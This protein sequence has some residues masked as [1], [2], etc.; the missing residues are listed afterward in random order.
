MAADEGTAAHELAAM[1]LQSDTSPNAEAYLGRRM[2]VGK[3]TFTVDRE[4]ADAV[5]L[6]V[7]TVLSIAEGHELLVEQRVDYSATLNVPN[8]FGTSDAIIITPDEII[9][10]D[11]KYGANPRNR[12]GARDNRQMKLYALGA[13]EEHGLVQNFSRVRMMIVQPRLDNP[14]SEDTITMDELQMFAAE[15][16][17]AAAHAMDLLAKGAEK[18]GKYDLNPTVKGCK[19][20]K[21]ASRCPARAQLVF[22]NVKEVE[23]DLHKFVDEHRVYVPDALPEPHPDTLDLIDTWVKAQRAEIERRLMSGATLANWKLVQGKAGARA[24]IDGDLA[25]TQLK[26]FRLK[27]EEMYDLKII[28]P[29]AAEKLAQAGTI[30]PKQWAKAQ[31]NIVK[32]EGKPSVAAMSDKKPAISIKPTIDDFDV[33][34]DGEDLV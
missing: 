4:M 25:E 27:V 9:V 12:V 28:S 18:V 29:T 33:I 6:Y 31:A 10:I 21:A 14:I 8:Q 24:W 3:R 7:S 13:L 5:N 19:W 30:G 22:D 34:S 26:Q 23:E 32:P 20:C 1:C 16:K 15:A 11:L 17:M 2:E